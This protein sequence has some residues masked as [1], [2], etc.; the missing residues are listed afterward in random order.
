MPI[1]YTRDT[2]HT[3]LLISTVEEPFNPALDTKGALESLAYYMG[4]IDGKVYVVSDMRQL[5][6]SFSEIIVGM[7]EASYRQD[8]P[9]RNDRVVIAQVATGQIF[10]L[11][12]D[13]FKQEQYGKLDMPLFKTVEEAKEFL[14]AKMEQVPVPEKA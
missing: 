3:S 13:W 9:V 4:E 10:E 7:A 6:P 8:S 12:A 14:V 1:V 5:S 11:M 2:E